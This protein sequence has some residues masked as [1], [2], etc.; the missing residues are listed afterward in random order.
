MPR[1]DQQPAGPAH[2]ADASL[3]PRVAP[4]PACR[5]CGAPVAPFFTDRAGRHY[6]RCGRC[7]LTQLDDGQLPPPELERALYRL[8]CNDP[9]DP[10]YRR[11]SAR[12]AAPL[13]ER[14]HP[15]AEGLDF[16]CGQGSALAALLQ[17]AGHRVTAYDPLFVPDL[18]ALERDYDFVACCEVV[19]HFHD[20]ATE[21]ARLDRL[22]RPGAWLAIMTCFQQDDD[23]FDGWHY[24]R[25]PTHVAFYR[26]ESFAWLAGCRG[27]RLELPTRNVALLQ[28]TAP[29]RPVSPARAASA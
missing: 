7:A 4:A 23:A 20:P 11:F 8:H 19:E 14:L 25:D 17:E 9:D 24:R 21:F 2:P 22:L 10:G 18:A 3:L 26:P 6:Q 29:Q 16:G 27:W 28:K 1:P 15:G 5:L 12:L 13:H